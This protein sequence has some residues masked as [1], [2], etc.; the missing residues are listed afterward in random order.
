MTCGEFM[1]LDFV[2]KKETADEILEWLQKSSNSLEAPNLVAKY[3]TQ[4]EGEGWDAEKFVIEIEG[5]CQDASASM[6]VFDR[7]EEHS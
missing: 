5:H 2:Q 1:A 6:S 3:A 4:S 7:L